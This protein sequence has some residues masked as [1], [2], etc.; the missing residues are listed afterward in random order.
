[1][2]RYHAC[3]CFYYYFYCVISILFDG[4]CKSLVY[5]YLYYIYFSNFYLFA[6]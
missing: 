6:S 2:H 3:K 1:M 5:T 4:S